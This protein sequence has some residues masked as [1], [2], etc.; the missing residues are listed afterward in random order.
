MFGRFINRLISLIKRSFIFILVYVSSIY[1]LYNE[2]GINIYATI[3]ISMG[4]AVS[5]QLL[6]MKKSDILDLHVDFSNINIPQL[7]K[8]LPLKY[9]KI[10]PKT[11]ALLSGLVGLE[12]VKDNIINILNLI[13]IEQIRGEK[14]IVGHYIFKGNPGT[15]KTT[16]GRIL[17]QTFKELGLLKRGHFIEVSRNDLVG[18]YQ[19]HT[20]DKTTTILR[21]ALGGV[22]FIDEVY[23]LVNGEGDDFGRE[24][25][26]TIVPFMENHRNEF[27]L[28]VA[29]YTDTL[30]TFL[31]KN[32][33]LKS[34]FNYT[35][36]FEDY[37]NVQLYDIFEIFAY[38]FFWDKKTTNII[39]KILKNLVKN[40]CKHFGNAREVRKIFET[41]KQNQSNRLVAKLDHL[42]KDDPS[43]F[44]IKHN[45]LDMKL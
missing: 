1:I 27:I 24:A 43:L 4:I 16:V 8:T 6:R 13:K 35:I 38:K 21:K 17:G 34:R 19:G 29:G 20:A 23:S 36:E 30:D 26:N 5:I 25:I 3:A 7:S 9:Q 41:I 37:S 12:S 11:Y 39:K 44:E 42:Y 18:Q 2:V 45:D 22:L 10:Y 32:T 15:G 31:D 40:K 28:I 14:P 33:G